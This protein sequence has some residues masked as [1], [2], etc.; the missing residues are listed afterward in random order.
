MQTSGCQMGEGLA[1]SP[2]WDGT[3]APPTWVLTGVSEEATGPQEP[4]T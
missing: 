4:S 1:Y 3:L 2:L